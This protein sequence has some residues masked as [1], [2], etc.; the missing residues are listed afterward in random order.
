MIKNSPIFPRK[1]SRFFKVKDI[2]LCFVFPPYFSC[3][4]CTNGRGKP[5]S[6]LFWKGQLGMWRQRESQSFGVP[7]P[8]PTPASV[9]WQESAGKEHLHRSYVFWHWCWCLPT[10]QCTMLRS[11]LNC[12]LPLNFKPRLKPASSLLPLVGLHLTAFSNNTRL[13]IRLW[14]Q[15]MGQIHLWR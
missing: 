8:L 13:E 3:Q 2:H 10:P 1:C 11:Q 4:F 7:I 12:F 9:F 5:F 14:K 15:F 6:F